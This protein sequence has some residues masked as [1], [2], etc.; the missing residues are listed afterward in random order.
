MAYDLIIFFLG[1]VRG[2]T[3]AYI[4]KKSVS[5][6]GHTHDDRYFTESEVNNLLSG[7]AAS[8]PLGIGS[9]GASTPNYNYSDIITGQLVVGGFV[10]MAGD[11]WLVCH[12]DDT[13]R[14]C[15]YLC[16]YYIDESI[17]YAGS[18][19]GW[20]Y[21]TS[22][23]AQKC[24]QYA[25]SLPANVQNKLVNY[26]M[27][28]YNCKIFL[29]EPTWLVKTLDQYESSTNNGPGEFTY[30]T[31]NNKRIAYNRGG[32]IQYYWLATGIKTVN[33]AWN[34]HQNGYVYA[35][36]ATGN[37]GFRPFCCLPW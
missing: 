17:Q 19:S 36:R 13:E 9:G 20:E 16:K 27:Y 3:K 26:N 6:D 37:V 33:G 28:N 8:S 10:T 29:A 21:A 1:W 31:N 2:N 18:E 5:F 12:I 32:A 24:A 11:T 35:R 22:I 23:A 25:A 7:K 30:F 34:V 15:V 4:G 14:H